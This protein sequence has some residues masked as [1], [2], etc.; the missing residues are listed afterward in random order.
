MIAAG[1]GRDELELTQKLVK[2]SEAE[3]KAKKQSEAEERRRLRR[4]ESVE[5][6]IHEI[7]AEIADIQ[8]EM[9]L[10]ENSS[11]PA[12]M[13]EKASKMAE[14][15]AEVTELYDEWMELQ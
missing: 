7:E 14:L 6:R 2:D 12:W 11:D 4:A 5:N 8:D 10:P 15:E 1:G 3:R 9:S 13:H